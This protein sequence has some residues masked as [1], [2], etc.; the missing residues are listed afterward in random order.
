ME[1]HM[2][3][4]CEEV[5]DDGNEDDDDDASDG[6]YVCRVNLCRDDVFECCSCC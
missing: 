4:H 1:I 3:N 6:D 5:D 2:R